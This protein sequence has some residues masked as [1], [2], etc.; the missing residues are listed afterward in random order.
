[1]EAAII[2]TSVYPLKV[3]A[4]IVEIAVAEDAI[5]KANFFQYQALP[6]HGLFL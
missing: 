6:L 3:A 2:E 1:V 4:G 5:D